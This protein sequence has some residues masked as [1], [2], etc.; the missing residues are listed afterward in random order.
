MKTE[1]KISEMEMY[2][3]RYP[4]PFL[5]T[6]KFSPS[7]YTHTLHL[8]NVFVTVECNSICHQTFNFNLP[9]CC[10]LALDSYTKTQK[11]NNS[12]LYITLLLYQTVFLIEIYFG[13]PSNSYKFNSLTIYK[14][15]FPRKGKSSSF[16][17]FPR[18]QY[19]VDPSKLH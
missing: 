17:K 1:A 10:F 2:D 16:N 6:L 8:Q 5:Y 11:N 19:R 9:P 7:A 3:K 18:I 12:D 15:S 14:L 13:L 4:Y